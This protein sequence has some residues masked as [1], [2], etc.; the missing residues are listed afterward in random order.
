MWR[1]WRRT[2]AMHA[3]IAPRRSIIRTEG[4]RKLIRDSLLPS[5]ESMAVMYPSPENSWRIYL[6]YP[7]RLK[8]VLTRY[9]AT[10]WWLAR[11]D[12]KTQAAV[13]RTNQ[14]TA[15]RDWLMSD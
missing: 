6:Y 9:S 15:L 2:G 7:M 13:A 4:R 14:V 5:R 12:P 3:S 1:C 8:G 10:L 11:G